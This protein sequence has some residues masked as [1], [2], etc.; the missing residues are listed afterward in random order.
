M[1]K[2]R[3]LCVEA[4]GRTLSFGTAGVPFTA[5]TCRA[6]GAANSLEEPTWHNCWTGSERPNPRRASPFGQERPEAAHKTDNQR[7]LGGLMRFIVP[8]G[9]VVRELMAED[10]VPVAPAVAG[11]GR[12]A[13]VPQL[14][15]VEGVEEHPPAPIEGDAL[16][17]LPEHADARPRVGE[18]EHGGGQAAREP[19]ELRH[20]SDARP[21]A[22][23]PARPG[24]VLALVV[25]GQRRPRRLREGRAA[26]GRQLQRALALRI[27][28]LR[29]RRPQ[30]GHAGRPDGLVL[31][32]RSGRAPGPRQTP[33][34]S[35]H[36]LL[37]GG[38]HRVPALR[39][40]AARV[41]RPRALATAAAAAGTA[42]LLRTGRLK[43]M[44]HRRQLTLLTPGQLLLRPV[45]QKALLQL[46]HRQPLQLLQRGPRRP[47]C[48]AAGTGPRACPACRA[49]RGTRGGGRA[50]PQGVT[51]VAQ[52][53]TGVGRGGRRPLY[54]G[55][56][57]RLHAHH[58]ELLPLLELLPQVGLGLLQ[59]DQEGVGVAQQ[60]AGPAALRAVV[61]HRVDALRGVVL[62]DP[63]VG[64]AGVAQQRH[65][66]REEPPVSG[67]QPG[68]NSTGVACW[69]DLGM[70][71]G[72]AG[73]SR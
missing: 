61:L 49:G 25:Q 62:A 36:R 34:H 68:H 41:L 18:A 16:R 9:R 55:Q 66:H 24:L 31:S 32:D 67:I 6:L 69:E 8:G 35:V 10:D 1:I 27:A 14:R 57:A 5:E 37:L 60:R 48:I 38:A 33:P 39:R 63:L 54:V 7:F 52:G 65:V 20:E 47:P 58:R 56:V 17:V 15:R 59:A 46:R 53:V 42:R 22:A 11:Q 23:Q 12:A 43:G 3:Q 21:V 4:G 13:H 50:R 64:R 71:P 28:V 72:H 51:G 19:R 45:I 2:G 30:R 40:D 70:R 26:Q 29:C 73:A 44:H